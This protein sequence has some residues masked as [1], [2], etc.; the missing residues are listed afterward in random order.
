MSIQLVDG[1]TALLIPFRLP[2][3]WSRKRWAAGLLAR[4]LPIATPGATAA[5][6]WRLSHERAAEVLDLFPSFQ[7]ALLSSHWNGEADGADGDNGSIVLKLDPGL[8]ERYAACEVV[9]NNSEHEL[10]L[11]GVEVVVY[12]HRVGVLVLRVDYGSHGD[13]RVAIR[14]LIAARHLHSEGGV[15]GWVFKRHHGALPHGQ[16]KAEGHAEWAENVKRFAGEIRRA[17]H[18]GVPAGEPLEPVRLG[19]LANWLL[20]TDGEAPERLDPVV[21]GEAVRAG[22]R[23]P[24][25]ARIDLTRF[26]RHQSAFVLEGEPS[27]DVQTRLLYH[28]GRAYK[29]DYLVPHEADQLDVV[30]RP[31]RNRVV[32]ISREGAASISWLEPSA[33][34]VLEVY[35][36]P[37]KFLDF[38]LA[39]HVHVLAERIALSSCAYELARGAE[40]LGTARAEGS[41]SSS[42]AAGTVEQLMSRVSATFLR[43]TGNDTGGAS[44]YQHFYRGLRQVHDSERVMEEVRQRLADMEVFG[45]GWTRAGETLLA[46]ERFLEA[47]ELDREERRLEREERKRDRALRDQERPVGLSSREREAT[48]SGG[49]ADRDP[50]MHRLV[51]LVAFFT[52][53]FATLQVL[54]MVFP[55]YMRSVREDVVLGMSTLFIVAYLAWRLTRRV[56]P[57]LRRAA[58]PAAETEKAG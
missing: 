54:G 38:Y 30:L 24:S 37:A 55:A 51:S 57:R 3:G 29:D 17:L 8:V 52:I 36:W 4:R 41:T 31:R 2:E 23:L 18:D 44:E 5:P 53:V 47:F 21:H 45:G 42:A 13:P 1:R 12:P 50:S 10:S 19:T 22:Q 26:A 35:Q 39:L 58:K 48:M 34:E 27:T 14:T 46:H 15:R 43:A 28:L 11:A 33:N 25:Q 16:L 49:L 6:M 32:G 56:F 20:L 7:D 9:T 40:Q